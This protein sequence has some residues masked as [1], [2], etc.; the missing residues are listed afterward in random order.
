[1]IKRLG[2]ACVAY[3]EL[4][5]CLVGREE[6]TRRIGCEGGKERG[7][8]VLFFSALY[9]P[10]YHSL[11]PANMIIQYSFCYGR[12]KY[13]KYFRRRLYNKVKNDD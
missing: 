7:G 2:A 9:L 6:G 13:H 1:M 11:R 10:Y 8:H 3:T 12:K 4:D 5:S